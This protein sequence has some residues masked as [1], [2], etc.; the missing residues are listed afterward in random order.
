MIKQERKCILGVQDGRGLLYREPFH[1]ERLEIESNCVS[2]HI[3]VP[4]TEIISKKRIS[5]DITKFKTKDY[6]IYAIRKDYT[7]RSGSYLGFTRVK[8]VEGQCMNYNQLIYEYN[9]C[10]EIGITTSKVAAVE[11]IGNDM[12]KVY[13]YNRHVHYVQVVSK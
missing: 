7:K 8:P 6:D 1:L 4:K 2:K 3:G 5:K 11:K 10:R 12:Y 9:S 13:T